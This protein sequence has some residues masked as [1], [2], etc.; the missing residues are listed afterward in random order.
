MLIRGTLVSE[1]RRRDILVSR[2]I[3]LDPDWSG[4][5]TMDFDFKVLDLW[6]RKWL[7]GVPSTP[8][9]L[10]DAR[11]AAAEQIAKASFDAEADQIDSILAG[12]G[13]KPVFRSSRPAMRKA[14]AS[15]AAIPT[16]N[17]DMVVSEAERTL[18]AL[19]QLGLYSQPLHQ[20]CA[21]LRTQHRLLAHYRG[22]G[23]Q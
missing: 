5:Q 23:S 8:D 21:L 14:T 12:P 6:L 15:R 22:R 4:T 9:Y 18:Y 13:R 11:V 16:L 17:P 19:G 20:A 7:D 10:R 3:A 1:Y 2:R